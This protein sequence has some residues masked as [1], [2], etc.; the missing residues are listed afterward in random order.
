MQKQ[1]CTVGNLTSVQP[2]QFW[3]K[4]PIFFSTYVFI[5]IL[6]CSKHDHTKKSIDQEILISTWCLA[7]WKPDLDSIFWRILSKLKMDEQTIPASMSAQVFENLRNSKRNPMSKRKL[8]KHI[9][10][11]FKT[12]LCSIVFTFSR[13]FTTATVIEPCCMGAQKLNVL[14]Y[15]VNISCSRL[16]NQ[17]HERFSY[18]IKFSL[19]VFCCGFWLQRNMSSIPVTKIWTKYKVIRLQ[20]K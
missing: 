9:Y 7:L 4:K 8:D 18:R 20:R 13:I 11:C 19:F 14:E 17:P 6:L 2:I 12:N 10:I 15:I 5:S 16:I 3:K 1:N